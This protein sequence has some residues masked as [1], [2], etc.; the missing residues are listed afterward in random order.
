ME[1]ICPL[2][3]GGKKVDDGRLRQ[4]RE[5]VGV[6]NIQAFNDRYIIAVREAK[7][8]ARKFKKENESLRRMIRI[9]QTP[10]E[11]PTV[12]ARELDNYYGEEEG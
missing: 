4:S 10:Y 7:E 2:P 9:L 12:A 3:R 5:L 11:P 1:D 8:E 6:K